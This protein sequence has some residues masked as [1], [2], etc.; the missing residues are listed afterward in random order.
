MSENYKLT[1][2]KELSIEEKAKAYDNALKVANKYKDTYIMFPSIKEEMFPELKESDDERIRKA[3]I[4]FFNRF[5]YDSIEAAGT[6]AKEAI[7]WLEKQGEIIKEWSEMKVA[8]IQKELQEMVD[9]KQKTE[10]G[11]QKPNPCDGC[12]NRRGC[13]NCENGELR[14]TEH[15]PAPVLD[16]EIPFGAKDSELQEASYYIP[17]GFH[18]EIEGNRVVIKR[19]KQKP[20]DKVKPKFK[21]GDTIRLK[22]GDGK[23]WKIEKIREDGYTMIGHGLDETDFLF[24]D[25]KWEVVEQNPAWSEEDERI[26]SQ[27]INEIEAIK[28]NSSTV[29]EKNIAQDKIDWLKSL[30]DRVQP[31][32]EWSEEDAKTLNRISV[33]LV[34]A[35]EV[36]NWWKEYRLIERD[37]MIRLTDF[38]KS[39]RPQNRWKPSER[40]LGSLTDAIIHYEGIGIKPNGL[41][42]LLVKLKK[43]RE[44]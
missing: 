21:E 13:I 33:I 7:A 10:Q 30:K 5:P 17:E 35:S 14:E 15:K 29:F 23:L 4:T 12:I 9:L 43:L 42:E 8:N 2:M 27:V 40:D 31:Q 24:L 16:I 32:Q 41:K 39:L 25:D 11:E 34:D 6:N 44:E 19:G 26:W 3:L 20:A 22:E 1:I 36:K 37:E 28:S 18:A 38:L